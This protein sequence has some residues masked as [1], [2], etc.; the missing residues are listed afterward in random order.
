[1]RYSASAQ[2]AR[3]VKFVKMVEVQLGKLVSAHANV[4]KDSQVQIARRQQHVLLLTILRTQPLQLIARIAELSKVQ[5]DNAT[6][7]VRLD[8]AE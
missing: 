3:M 4:Y 6:V 1:V 8:I 7:F 5:L 2:E